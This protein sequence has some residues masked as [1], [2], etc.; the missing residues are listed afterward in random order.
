MEAPN[1]PYLGEL[2]GQFLVWVEFLHIFYHQVVPNG[3]VHPA[4]LSGIQIKRFP[5]VGLD[6]RFEELHL[7]LELLP[8]RPD[9]GGE[10]PDAVQWGFAVFKIAHQEY[11]MGKIPQIVL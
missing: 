9:K 5:E 3:I 2:A 7:E 11:I 4:L 8:I 6:G 1:A 10:L